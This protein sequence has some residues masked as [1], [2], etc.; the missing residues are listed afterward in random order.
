MSSVELVSKEPVA[1][2][3]LGCVLPDAPDVRT[4]WDNLLAGRSSIR[5]VPK[6]RWDPALYFDA[7]KSVVDKTYTKIG[8]FVL[9]DAFNGLE[10]RMPPSTV[11]QIDPVQRWA[12]ASTRQALK[13]AGYKTGLKG[14]EGKDFDRNRCAIILGNAMGGELQKQTSRRVYWPEAAAAVRN[15]PEF[16]SLP[17]AQRD[18]ILGGAEAEFKG[19]RAE[20]PAH[21]PRDRA[22]AGPPGPNHPRFPAPPAAPGRRHPGGGGGEVQGRPIPVTEDTMPGSLSNVVA[23]RIANLFDLS[24]KN[25]T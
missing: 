17:Q 25:F 23:G 21:P 10:Y 19:G 12:L 5:E 8:G 15:N 14:D 16:Q 13:D 4:F 1:I 11:A 24:G 6:D 9:N 2:I 7:D 20:E 22:G 3:G 18:A